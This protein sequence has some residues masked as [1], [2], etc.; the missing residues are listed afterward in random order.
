MR[1][2]SRFV[3]DGNRIFK[4]L[5]KDKFK[6]RID[7]RFKSAL[8]DTK[9]NSLHEVKGKKSTSSSRNELGEYYRVDD[10]DLPSNNR[11]R[12]GKR[13][14]SKAGAKDG[15]GSSA[16]ERLDYLNKL[17][18]GDISGESSEEEAVASDEESECE[19]ASDRAHEDSARRSSLQL[20]A[21]LP[22][23]QVPTGEATSRLAVM[24]C[25]WQNL[26]ALDLM[27]VLQSFCPAGI[28]IRSVNVYPSDFGLKEM[29]REN[30]LGPQGIWN[31]STRESEEEY[32][33]DDEEEEE[34][35]DGDDEEELYD[36]LQVG[37]ASA[38]G[39]FARKGGEAAIGVVFHNE[40][41]NRG[42]A[43]P[44]SDDDDNE[45]GAAEGKSK[46]SKSA[47]KDPFDK[48]ALR[49]YELSKLRYYF[50]VVECDTV[51]TASILYDRMDGMEFEHSA[52]AFDLRFIPDDVRYASCSIRDFLHAFL[53][54]YSRST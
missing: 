12:D 50:A 11:K 15:K 4:P 7:D 38:D 29:A 22:E 32:A 46:G 35:D 25:D 43:E 41:C 48:Q 10:D 27:M 42:L 23:E 8:S 39:E 34:D 2:D 44:D 26:R 1:E 33:S 17:A 21:T 40:L 3:V 13:I 53:N 19:E 9:F 54:F 14:G 5:K 37:E 6:V 47:K 45:D 36:S 51:A 18:R 49:L 20:E 16:E 52:M 24:N 30:A 31:T 28:A